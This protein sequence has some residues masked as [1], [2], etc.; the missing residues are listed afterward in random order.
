MESINT[1]EFAN[2]LL[3]MSNEASK[4]KLEYIKLA[5]KEAMSEKYAKE[6]ELSFEDAILDAQKKCDISTIKTLANKY[7]VTILENNFYFLCNIESFD[8]RNIE[9]N[10]EKDKIYICHDV[11][12]PRISNECMR[13][14]LFGNCQR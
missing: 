6:K 10:N 5:V 4:T 12:C 2:Y 11:A 7:G 3:E 9:I 14:L 1:T 8:K 13:R